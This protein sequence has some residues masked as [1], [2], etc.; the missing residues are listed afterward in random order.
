M[1]TVI[2]SVAK[3]PCLQHRGYGFFGLRPQNDR[4]RK[5]GA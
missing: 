2:L 1:Q 4:L 3:D 5:A